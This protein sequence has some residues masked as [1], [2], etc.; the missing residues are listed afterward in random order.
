MGRLC[1]AG[2]GFQLPP[3]VHTLIGQIKTATKSSSCTLV[4]NLQLTKAS[5]AVLQRNLPL[6]LR[7]NRSIRILLIRVS[8]ILL[9]RICVSGCVNSASSI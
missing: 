5:Y 2:F 7:R 6:E 9:K 3:H 8:A 4:V 1:E